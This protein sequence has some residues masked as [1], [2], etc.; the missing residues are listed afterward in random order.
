MTRTLAIPAAICAVAVALLVGLLLG[1]YTAPRPTMAPVAGGAPAQPASPP[2]PLVTPTP[3]TPAVEPSA[4]GG[5]HVH[6]GSG[7]ASPGPTPYSQTGDARKRWQPV[8]VGFGAKFTKTRGK[9]S[10]EWAAKLK[11]YSTAAV[12]QQLGT[13]DVRNVPRGRYT[14]FDV[15]QYDEQQLAARVFYR[16]PQGATWAM[17]LHVIDDGDR[18]RVYRYDRYEE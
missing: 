10:R 4:E 2:H 16:D 3:A 12:Q 13:V 17:M 11:P 9:S 7:D 8:V 6:E 5:G 14:G 15:A 1:R 18:W